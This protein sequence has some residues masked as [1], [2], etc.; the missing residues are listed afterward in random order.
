MPQILQ[1][2]QDSQSVAFVKLILN[3]VKKI[4]IIQSHEFTSTVKKEQMDQFYEIIDRALKISG[5]E[6]TFLIGDL[7][8]NV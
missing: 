6:I 7:N 4:K 1:R 3:H 8:T 5:S 2:S